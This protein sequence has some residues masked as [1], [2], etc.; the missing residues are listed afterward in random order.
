MNI[1][2]ENNAVKR[3]ND[4]FV[5]NALNPSASLQ[6]FKTMAIQPENTGLED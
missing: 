2:I 4:W 6:D 5:A 1:M 3:P